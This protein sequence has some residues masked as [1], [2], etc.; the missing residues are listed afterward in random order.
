MDLQRLAPT[1]QQ[2]VQL[3]QRTALAT[4]RVKPRHTE[5]VVRLNK[6]VLD[7]VLA[8]QAGSVVEQI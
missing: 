6:Q 3:P 1:R 2:V 5:A 7:P 4:E 8:E